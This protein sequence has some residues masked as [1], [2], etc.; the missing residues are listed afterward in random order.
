MAVF[1]S[2]RRSVTCE[3]QRIAHFFQ[4]SNIYLKWGIFKAHF[5]VKQVKYSIR[6]RSIADAIFGYFDSFGFFENY[7][8]FSLS[9]IVS[10]GHYFE[11]LI[12]MK[13][14]D[15]ILLKKVIFSVQAI[16]FIYS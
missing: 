9:Y 15:I 4:C 2:K 5:N 16:F 6:F 14:K 1:P 13:E 11:S 8:N 10:I 7:Y 3:Q 12:E